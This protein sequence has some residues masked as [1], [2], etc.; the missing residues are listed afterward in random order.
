MILSDG[1]L[2]EALGDGRLGVHPLAEGAIQPSS[3][4]VRLGSQFRVFANHRYPYIDVREPQPDLT[5]LVE[6]GDEPFVLHPGEFVLG[7]TYESVTL[8]ADIA[9]FLAS[10]ESYEGDGSWGFEGGWGFEEFPGEGQQ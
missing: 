8:P 1:T 7:A 9:E 5:E 3:I 4:D 2:R 6:A 10:T